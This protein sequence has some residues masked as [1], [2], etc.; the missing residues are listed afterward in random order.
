MKTTWKNILA[1]GLLSLTTTSWAND[2]KL[3]LDNCHLGEIRSQVK[4][5]KLEVPENYQQAD[6]DMV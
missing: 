3:T 2:D 6:G 5:G 1:L 4:C